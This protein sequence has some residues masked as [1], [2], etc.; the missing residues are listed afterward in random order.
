MNTPET[1]LF[2]VGSPEFWMG[3]LRRSRAAVRR[4][5]VSMMVLT[6][7]FGAAGVMAARW[8]PRTYSAEVRLLVRK[9]DVMPALAH[10]RR[11]VPPSTDSLTQS[12]GD[13]IRDRQALASIV[14]RYELA[15]RWDA[16]RPAALRVK[17]QVFAWLGAAPSEADKAEVLVDVLAKRIAVTVD[18]QI[19]TVKARWTDAATTLDLVE[20]ATEAYLQARRRVDIDAIAETYA[21]LE[22]TADGARHDVERQIAASTLSQRTRALL[23][24]MV[25]SV[26]PMRPAEDPL[27]PTR[28]RAIEALA[29]RDRLRDAHEAAVKTLEDE[30]ADRLTRETTRHPDVQ[31]LSRQVEQARVMP[32]E[33]AEAIAEADRLA[34]AYL[35]AGG[36][37]AGLTPVRATQPGPAPVVDRP[38]PAVSLTRV[39]EDDEATLYARSLLESSIAAYQDLLERLSNTRIELE[40]ARAAFDYRYTTVAAARLPRKADSPNGLLMVI[41]AL[42]AGFGVGVLRAAAV[43]LRQ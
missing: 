11:S 16:D 37:V 6:L 19:I 3:V 8:A 26:E 38:R 2:P 36:R 21:L 15:R 29:E 24:P 5:W 18:G 43:E 12:A 23:T 7:I 30:L 17:D 20:A 25:E 9:T 13:L 31:A 28:S 39:L 27:V 32:G 35:A 41:G 1:S 42:V 14:D 22:R 10:P 34:A 40:T 33:L 4:S